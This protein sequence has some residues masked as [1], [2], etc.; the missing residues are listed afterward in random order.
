MRAR[1]AIRAGALL[2]GA[3]WGLVGYCPGPALAS[4]GVGGGRTWLFVAAMLI[5]M[6]AFNLFSRMTPGRHVVLHSSSPI[7]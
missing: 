6:A 1:V 7:R 3:G 2:F 5:G 4:L